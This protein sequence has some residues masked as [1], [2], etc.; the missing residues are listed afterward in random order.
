MSWLWNALA[1]TYMVLSG[2]PF[3]PFLAVYWIG[4]WRGLENRKAVRLAADVTT[5]FLIGIVSAL[6]STRTGSSFG[7]FFVA[8]VMLIGAGLIGNAQTRAHGKIN[9]PKIIRAVWRLSFF[10]L[11]ILYVILM[12]IELIFPSAIQSQ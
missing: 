4:K 9:P 6:L 12:T 7:F 3:I 5:V 10:G 8:L 1:N 11:S 2:L